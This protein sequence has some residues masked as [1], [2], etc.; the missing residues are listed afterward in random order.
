MPYSKQITNFQETLVI[1]KL[2]C[3]QN[4]DR[5]KIEI[6]TG[7]LN[8]MSVDTSIFKAYDIRGTYPTQ[9]NEEIAYRIGQAFVRFIEPTN[10][11]IGYDVRISSRP[12]FEALSNGITDMG[13]DVINV[14]EVATDM[15][16]FG[17]PKYGYDSGI[18]ITASH[19]PPEYNGMK[20]VK[21]Q[22]IPISGD[23]GIY[24]IME[25]VVNSTEHIVKNERGKIIFKDIYDDYIKHILSFVT[26]DNIKPYKIVMD[27]GNGIAGK[28]VSRLAEHLPIQIIPMNFEP[29]GHFPHGE[30]NPLLE[31]KRKN[32]ME[33][34][35]LESADLGVA[36][37][38]D[39][40]RCF[41]IDEHGNFVH[42]YYITALLAE[43]FLKKTPGE[44]II[45]D[46]RLIWAN[47]DI[48]KQ[49]DGI[50]LINKSGHAFIK[51]RMR[52]ENALFAGEMSAHYYFRDNYYADNGMIPLVLILELMSTTNKSLNELLAPITS[53][54]FIS[55]EINYKI[56]SPQEK[57][58]EV[59]KHYCDG[60]IEYIDGLSVE[61]DMWR[62]NLRASNTEPLIR[63]NIEAKNK[64]ILNG[65]KQELDKIIRENTHVP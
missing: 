8:S 48:I 9:L 16:Y 52:K 22:A 14:G 51:E 34:V 38:G 61:Y 29:D 33:R 57:I 24:D 35:R 23:T 49:Y 31:E 47:I 28:I 56:S 43:A 50:P 41:F 64:D 3:Y 18:I 36:W 32:I 19:N 60:K 65:K 42:G 63:L 7:G 2:T 12:L 45:F 10:V 25:L 21:E 39:A 58:K 54:Y 4:Y 37:D 13:V 55:G 30:P 1:I 27:A 44:K 40:D 17:V 59:E 62:F 26:I 15:V 11:M 6:L 20:L 46:P 53:K 5:I